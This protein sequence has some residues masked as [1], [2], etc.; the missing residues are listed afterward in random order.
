MMKKILFLIASFYCLNSNSANAQFSFSFPSPIDT[1]SNY[2]STSGISDSLAEER[3]YKSDRNDRNT[4]KSYAPKPLIQPSSLTFTPNMQVRKQTF[5][6]LLADFDKK[7]PGIKNQLRPVLYGGS[8]GDIIEQFDS[9]I[10]SEYGFRSNN[11]ADAYTIYWITASDATNGLLEKKTTIFQAKAVKEQVTKAF[12]TI[13]AVAQASPANKQ[14]YAEVLLIQAALIGSLAQQVRT[15]SMKMSDMQTN[16]RNGAKALGVDLDTFVLTETG[17]ELK[18]KKRSDATNAL[19]GTG[20]TQMAATTPADEG[21]G[22]DLLPGV[23]IA[24]LAGSTLAAAFLY[25]KNKSS[26]KGNG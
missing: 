1:S 8:S 13:P 14:A 18:N 6:N 24:G 15:G 5:N 7:Q 17:F 23:L 21:S 2:I 19:P 9:I 12:L 25:G 16:V 26:K 10:T 22:S 20:D 11:L 3:R 4:N